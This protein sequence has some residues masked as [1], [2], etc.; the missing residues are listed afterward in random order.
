MYTNLSAYSDEITFLNFGT[1]FLS[2]SLDIGESWKT[3][4]L[5]NYDDIDEY[6]DFVENYNVLEK[7]TL[8]TEMGKLKTFKI[9]YTGSG[10]PHCWSDTCYYW[11][12]KEIFYSGTIWYSPKIGI[13]EED[14]IGTYSSNGYDF[15]FRSLMG[16]KDVNFDY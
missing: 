1:T 13:V 7:V 14:V 4:F 10:K 16:I 9:V 6:Y 12:S 2:D 15:N 3:K 11:G 8:N 5:G